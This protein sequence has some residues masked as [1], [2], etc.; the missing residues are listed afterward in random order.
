MCRRERERQTERQRERETE[1][2]CVWFVCVI[3]RKS[4]SVYV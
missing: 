4:E 1:R 3:E 2:E